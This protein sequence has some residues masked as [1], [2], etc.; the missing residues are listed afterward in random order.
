[1]TQNW[2]GDTKQKLNQD[3]IQG[4][5]EVIIPFYSMLVK[6]QPEYWIEWCGLYFRKDID[7]LENIQRQQPR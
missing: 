7:S 6:L 2:G 4:S 3:K 1:M 5:K